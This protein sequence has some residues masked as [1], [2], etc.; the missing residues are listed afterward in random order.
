MKYLVSMALLGMIWSGPTIA[1]SFAEGSQAKE[2]GLFGEEK[3]RF[4]GEVVD[5]VCALTGDCPEDCG[6]GNRQMGI[7]RDADDAL[8]LVSKNRQTSFNGAA[9][10]LAPYCHQQVE[11]DGV[12][13]GDPDIT[14]MGAKVYLIQLIRPEGAEDWK[15]TSGWTKDW[16]K[17]YPDSKGKGPWFR[18]DP[19]VKAEIEANGYLGLGAEAD[20]AYAAENF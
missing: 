20:A 12:L 13:V 3:A 4:S 18:R 10:D 9:A 17:R 8:V 19:R 15:K 1:E 2:W 14:P 7:I 11:V 5:I 16:A 6:A